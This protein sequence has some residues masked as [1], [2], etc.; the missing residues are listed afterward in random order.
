VV[1]DLALYKV[2]G[3]TRD[4]QRVR[5]TREDFVDLSKFK[6]S[7]WLKVGGG[8]LF[9]IA[10]ILKWWGVDCNGDAT[11]E[12][13]ASGVGFT[14]FDFFFTGIVPW[15]LLVA[16][17]VLTFL[18]AAGIFRLPASIPAPIVFLAG[19]ALSLLLVV[20]RFLNA[21]GDSDLNDG[22]GR[23]IG[24]FLALIGAIVSLVGCV[25]GFKES[26]GD[27]NDL[28]DMNKIKGA[29][30][31]GESSGGGSVPPP[32]PPP[33]NMPPPPPAP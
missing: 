17:A 3:S 28:T 12:R 24:L 13:F 27:L 19:A 21:P 23:K 14:G 32:P 31:Q 8:A 16:I 26:G 6:T 20:L 11:C 22:I 18:A 29:F 10:G 2:Y 30:N 5:A 25:L 7:D 33:G 15:L 9:L 1:R 4:G